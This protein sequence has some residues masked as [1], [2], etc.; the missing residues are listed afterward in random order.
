M[1]GDN[2]TCNAMAFRSDGKAMAIDWQGKR[3]NVW[4]IPR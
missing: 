1:L 3:V 2:E 4:N